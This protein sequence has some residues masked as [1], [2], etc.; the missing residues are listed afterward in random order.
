MAT[1]SRTA[2]A[3]RRAR[4]QPEPDPRKSDGNGIDR[5]AWV[6]CERV[7]LARCACERSQLT[8]CTNLRKAAE[9][10]VEQIARLAP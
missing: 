6:I 7:N 5:I 1:L 3:A 4:M 2:T 10:A 8:P 9:A